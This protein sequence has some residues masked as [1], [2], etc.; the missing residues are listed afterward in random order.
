MAQSTQAKLQEIGLDMLISTECLQSSDPKCASN[1]G[2]GICLY[3]KLAPMGR[4][5]S[6]RL[7]ERGI[8]AEKVG[9]KAALNLIQQVNSRAPID[10]FLGDQLIPFLV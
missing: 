5:G 10:K 3:A 2:M 1:P 8:P 4:L 9:Q 6:D 7:G